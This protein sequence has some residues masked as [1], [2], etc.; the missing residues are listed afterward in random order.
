MS[1]KLENIEENVVKLTIE[2][3]KEEF[4]KALEKSY[5]KNV[6]NITVPG[7][8]KGKAPRK[9]IEKTY[10]EGIFYEDAIDFCLPEAYEKAVKEANIIPVSRPEVDIEKISR[11]EGLVFTAKVTVKP[12]VTVEK[13]KGLEIEKVE[14][15]VTD[16]DVEDE[17]LRKREQTAR[18][19]SVE[20]RPIE[21]GDI[22][23]IDFEGFIDGT[24]FPGGKG[25]NYSLEIGSETFI[26][27]FEEQLIGKSK[28]EEVVVNVT[29]PEDYHA[30]DLK[31]KDAVFKVKVH[32]IKKK[33]LPEADDEFAKD[34]SEFD[35]LEELKADIRKKLEKNAENRTKVEI[36]NRVF[37]K[38]IENVK[39]NLPDCMVEDQVDRMVH[40]TEH[41]L[42]SQ[43]LT[44]E[45]YLSYIGM[46]MEAFRSQFKERARR[47]VLISLALEKIVEME[48]IE[49]TEED[50]EKEYEKI[51]QEYNLEVDKVRE[52]I[53]G[54][55]ESLKAELKTTKAIELL[56]S[57][58]VMK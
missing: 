47:D 16:K 11:E 8:R 25:E 46:D 34:V 57:T 35:T 28:G 43:G 55:V 3:D 17:I 50:L 37:D 36:E 12:E 48:N 27:G 32:E 4:E 31:G 44:L 30:E 18:L 13:Y 45:Q 20:D 38:L 10:G 1:V 6:K 15:T 22:A 33:E 29:F 21:K 24:A 58:A 56:T 7:F 42:Q 54:N 40:E 5:I 51:A 41:R 19:V 49:V 52:I 2:V 14:Y 26:P 53:S 23:V 9:Y 39:V